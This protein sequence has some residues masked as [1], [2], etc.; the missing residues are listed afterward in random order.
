MYALELIFAFILGTIIGSFL[1]VLILRYNTGR[2]MGG[3]SMCLSCGKTL[4]WYELIPLISFLIQRGKCRNCGS[5]ISLQYFFVELVTGIIFA[6]IIMHYA[7]HNWTETFALPLLADILIWRVLIVIFVYD[8]RHK[9]IPDGFVITFILASLIKIFLVAGF[10]N[11]PLMA[12]IAGPILFLPFFL[13]WFFSQ[14]RWIGLG[15]GK[16]ALGIGWMLGLSDAVSAV[17]IGVWG[18]AI[19][20]I[21]VLF[22][23]KVN[24]LKHVP[25]MK[26]ISG[27]K[28]TGKTEI[29]FAPFLIFGIA[30]V[31]FFG[32]SVI[33]F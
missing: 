8:L 1:N 22:L 31:Y 14:G 33:S 4:N 9:I 19:V 32:W 30:A 15:D 11:V 13:L 20:S 26:K 18:G 27:R 29:P 5:R 17:L 7:V 2:G 24:F 10:Y 25:F 12:L 3:R 21:C 6:A 28:L 16:L 23:G